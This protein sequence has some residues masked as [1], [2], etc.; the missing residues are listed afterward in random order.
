MTLSFVLYVQGELSSDAWEEKVDAINFADFKF[1]V[2][3]HFL[4]T[5]DESQEEV[6]QGID[7]SKTE[8]AESSAIGKDGKKAGKEE[9]KADDNDE[10]SKGD[11]N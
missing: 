6:P 3:Q 4:K 7:G 1:V 5:A 2:C 8:T 10:I 9:L 11:T